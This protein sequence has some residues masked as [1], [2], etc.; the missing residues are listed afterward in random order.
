MKARIVSRGQLTRLAGTLVVLARID[1]LLGGLS[2]PDKLGW[3]VILGGNDSPEISFLASSK[4]YGVFNKNR[5][6][7]RKEA[8]RRKITS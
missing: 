6:H 2:I 7:R 4:N 8:Y 1:P 3:L 5:M